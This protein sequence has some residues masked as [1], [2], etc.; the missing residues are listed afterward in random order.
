[1]HDKQDGIFCD[2]CNLSTHRWC[3]RVSKLVFTDN[4][5]LFYSNKSYKRMEIEV[6]ISLDNFANWLKTNNL[7][8]NVKNSV[9]TIK[10]FNKAYR[11]H[12]LNNIN[13]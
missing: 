12:L 7:T 10:A 4:T 2:G 5:C 6:N 8:L 1:M 11:K 13:A 9:K 3:A